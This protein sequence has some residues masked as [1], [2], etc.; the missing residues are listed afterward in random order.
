MTTERPWPSP[1]AGMRGVIIRE[2]KLGVI[3][4]GRT[5][6]E[7]SGRRSASSSASVGGWLERVS[8]FRG[9]G[10]GRSRGRARVPPTLTPKPSLPLPLLLTKLLTTLLLVLTTYFLLLSSTTYYVRRTW[11][12]RVSMPVMRTPMCVRTWLGGSSTLGVMQPEV[13][14]HVQVCTLG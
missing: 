5:S 7:S 2:T 1:G 11:L 12:E 9:R 4:T 8:G 6:P 13:R 14:G 3:I 10:R